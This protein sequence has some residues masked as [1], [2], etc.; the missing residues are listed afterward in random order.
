[1]SDNGTTRPH[2]EPTQHPLAISAEGRHLVD[3]TGKPFL[4]VGDAAWSILVAL[5]R[6]DAVRYLDDRVSRGFNSIMVNLLEYYFSPD[7]PNN[8]YGEPPFTTP[9][10]FSTPNPAYFDHARW[11]LDRAAE[12]NLLVLLYPCYLGYREAGWPGPKSWNEGWFGEVIK[13]G[14]D[15]CRA[16]GRFVGERFGDL[17]NLLWVMGGDADPGTALVPIGQMAEGIKEADPRHLM[18]AHC[19]PESVPSVEYRGEPW[20]DI[21][22]TYTYTIVHAR[23]YQDYV[24]VPTKPTFLIESSYENEHTAS[25]IQL[26]RQAY[27]SILRGGF[28]HMFGCAPIW[29]F[30]K[31]WEASLDGPGSRGMTRFAEAFRDRPWWKL[32]PEA[33]PGVGWDPC[34]QGRRLLVEG[35]GESRGLDFASVARTPDGKLAMAYMPTPRT[36]K[37]DGSVLSGPRVRLSWFDPIAGGWSSGGERSCLEPIDVAP[38]GNQD[39]L[40]AIESVS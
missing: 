15:R 29:Y 7:P 11:V 38:P 8:L 33:A 32:E 24:R 9:G 36:L 13:N 17:D 35:H 27:W 25:E 22:N 10:D 20:L 1:M 34:W 3:R 28:G 6:E 19:R 21:N 30:G 16:Y 31:G 18:T 2:R 5:S 37:L 40:L 14:F 23:L 4:L 39:W 26:R 12:R